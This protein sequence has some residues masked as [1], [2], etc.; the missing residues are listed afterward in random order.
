MT[1][2]YVLDSY[3]L[4]ALL[5]G[6]DGADAVEKIISSD[7]SEV[8][9]S[10]M[11][12][13]EVFYILCRRFGEAAACDLE[14]RILQTPKIR[15]AQASWERVRAAAIIKATGGLSFADCFSASLALELEAVLVTGDPEFA[16]LQDSLG[17]RIL[18]LS[19]KG[20]S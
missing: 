11:N 19:V 18:W 7:E 6:E 10:I 8:Y 20:N 2:R 16:R 14:T 15:I 5:Q 9:M 4:L 13:G 1:G 3:G 12:L 17:L